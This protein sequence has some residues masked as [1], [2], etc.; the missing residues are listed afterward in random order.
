[1]HVVYICALKEFLE[2][3]VYSAYGLIRCGSDG[4]FDGLD[5]EQSAIRD[6]LEMLFAVIEQAADVEPV[7]NVRACPL[8]NSSRKD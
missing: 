8:K 4:P 3:L 6:L 7:A 2:G 5:G 1:M